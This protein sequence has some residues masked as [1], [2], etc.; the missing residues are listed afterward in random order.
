MGTVLGVADQKAANP[1]KG[2]ERLVGQNEGVRGEVREVVAYDKRPMQGRAK[3][4]GERDA[5]S[6]PRPRR[7]EVKKNDK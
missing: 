1:R 7:A 2:E 3:K 6:Q 4:N 5:G